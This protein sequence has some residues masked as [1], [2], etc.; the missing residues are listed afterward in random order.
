VGNL[1]NWGRLGGVLYTAS[2]GYAHIVLNTLVCISCMHLSWVL[3]TPDVSAVLIC[4]HALSV[5][6]V[7]CGCTGS[8]TAPLHERHKCLAT[9]PTVVADPDPIRRQSLCL[10]SMVWSCIV[11]LR[12]LRVWHHKVCLA[13]MCTQVSAAIHALI[14]HPAS[15][16]AQHAAGE[17]TGGLHTSAER[18]CQQKECGVGTLFA[19]FAY[20]H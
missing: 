19:G 6:V 18:V 12:H 11:E 8:G 9:P 7:C 14:M 1:C 2:V 10:L 13:V 15:D 5:P 4:L 17:C 20:S 3:L 16:Q